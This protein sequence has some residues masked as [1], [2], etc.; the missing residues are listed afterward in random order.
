M[1]WKVMLVFIVLLFCQNIYSQSITWQRT[2]DGPYVVDYGYEVLSALNNEF[3]L[4]GYLSNANDYAYVLKINAFGDTL[5]SRSIFAGNNGRVY[6]AANSTD[7]GCVFVIQQSDSLKIAKIDPAGNFVWVK[8]M[9]IPATIWEIKLVSDGGFLACGNQ[10]LEGFIVK[11]NSIGDVVWYRQYQGGSGKSFQSVIEK[12]G[13]GYVL[14]GDVDLRP[15][16]DSSKTLLTKIDYTGNV[17]TEKYFGADKYSLGIKVVET[18]SNILIGGNCRYNELENRIFVLKLSQ[19]F[20]LLQTLVFPISTYTD[21]FFD[22]FEVINSNRYVIC[23]R[24]DTNQPIFQTHAKVRILDSN[25]NITHNWLSPSYGYSSF[26]SVIPL[27]N[28]DLIFGGTFEYYS[29]WTE[30]GFD[31]YAAR[32]DSNLNTSPFPPIGI[33]SNSSIVPSE[34]F[35]CQ[36][37]PNPFNPE[38]MI[39]YDIPKDAVVKVKVYDILGKQVF[40]LDEF[41]KA[42]SYELKFD[43]TNLASGIFFYSVEANGFKETKKMVLLK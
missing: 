10:S 25:F 41:K 42:G 27:V 8:G 16:I 5:W 11:Y 23:N 32:T 12:V 3:Y 21:E 33:T 19:T 14:T 24:L 34:Y 30:R 1:K 7:G 28:G 9:N 17:I 15:T 13:E 31:Y 29:V 22:D 4:V 18:N 38:T 40:G 36:N 20:G 26:T 35:L 39:K 37:Y 6:S 43:G 2:Y